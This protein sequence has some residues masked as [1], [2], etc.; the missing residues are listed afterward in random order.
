MT[1]TTSEEKGFVCLM[2]PNH[3]ASPKEART[4]P[5][6]GQDPI[7]CI[8]VLLCEFTPRLVLPTA[9]VWV[10]ML[11]LSSVWLV[12][13]QIAHSPVHSSEA[14]GNLPQDIQGREAGACDMLQKTRDDSG[15]KWRR[16]GTPPSQQFSVT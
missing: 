3:C 16:G 8:K 12:S 2:A 6:T 15:G 1:I 14:V 5:Q 10:S 7:F 9:C 11:L 4:G 13:S